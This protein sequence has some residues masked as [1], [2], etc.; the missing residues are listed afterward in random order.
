MKKV[1]FIHHS[2]VVGGAG[3][4]GIN[5]LKALEQ[6]EFEITVYCASKGGDMP[7]LFR[8]NG[9]KVIEAGSSPATLPHC[10]VFD[11]FIF[12]PRW[13]RI[14]VKCMRDIKKTKAVMKRVDPDIVVMNS[15][16]LF[17]IG[18]I[19]KKLG[20]TTMLFFRETYA[21]GRFGFRKSIIK[22]CLG[23]YID[24][25]AFISEFDMRENSSVRT[26]KRVIYNI[27]D[28]IAFKCCERAQSLRELSLSP[29][30]TY[31]LC[32]SGFARGKG[33]DTVIEAMLYVPDNVRLL[34]L[35]CAWKGRRKVLSDCKGLLSK[36]RFT[37]GFD[38]EQRLFNFIFDNELENKIRFYPVVK[39]TARFYSACDAVVIPFTKPHQARPLFEAGYSL[40]PVIISDFPNIAEFAD[41]SCCY[42]FEPGNARSLSSSIT[43]FTNNPVQAQ[44]KAMENRSRT[45]ARHSSQLYK[46]NIRDWFN[47]EHES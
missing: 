28:D 30:I 3:L 25:I 23:K 32:L 2:A 31:L 43:A 38:R 39:D 35:G 13:L 41:E 8:K 33:G 16:T 24:K 4:S 5:A 6:N 36:I 29:D 34:L 21:E 47:N 18:I 46:N 15:M 45:L 22:R 7:E 9:F 44:Q 20:K 17:Y 42:L 27:I 40:R 10:S 26:D 19:A 12:S 1:L 14:Y 37:T 11:E